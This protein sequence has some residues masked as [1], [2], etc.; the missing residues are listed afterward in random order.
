M[1]VFP[2]VA[3]RIVIPGRSRPLRSP[4]RIIQSAGRSLTEP[5]GFKCSAL[6]RICTPAGKSCVIFRNRTNGVLPILDS[7]ES[8]RPKRHGDSRT[9]AVM[10]FLTERLKTES[11]PRILHRCRD[12]LLRTLLRLAT[13]SSALHAAKA[14]T[15]RVWTPNATGAMTAAVIT[16]VV[17]DLVNRGQLYE[18]A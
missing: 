16:S 2:L 6:A 9:S 14:F 15:D 8:A 18:G 7:M 10:V 12:R 3:S 4:S 1:P 11:R 5:P 17:H 13:K